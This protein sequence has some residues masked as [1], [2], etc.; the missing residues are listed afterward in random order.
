MQG[1]GRRQGRPMGAEDAEGAERRREQRSAEGQAKQSRAT[2]SN[3]EQSKAAQA[4]AEGAP[5]CLRLRLRLP[6]ARPAT[7]TGTAGTR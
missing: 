7:P 4:E 6:T 5:G 1:P 3:A 2:Q